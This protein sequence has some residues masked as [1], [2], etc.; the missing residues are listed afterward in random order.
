MLSLPFLAVA[1]GPDRCPCL[2]PNISKDVFAFISS[3]LRESE[4]EKVIKMLIT[5]RRINTEDLKS[6]SIPGHKVKV[7][8]KAT[9]E[10]HIFISSGL[11]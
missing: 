9:G 5:K 11:Y 2:E 7:S 8:E 4:R 3:S 1:R 6:L 10:P